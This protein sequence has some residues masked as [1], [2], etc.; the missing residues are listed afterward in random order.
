[1]KGGKG[2]AGDLTEAGR[3]GRDSPGV[4]AFV[5]RPGYGDFTVRDRHERDDVIDEGP[6]RRD[7][8]GRRAG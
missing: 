5:R 4:G 8:P 6:A 1:M 7:R 3:A 2:G